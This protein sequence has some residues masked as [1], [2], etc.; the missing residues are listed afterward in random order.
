MQG[1]FLQQETGDQS[2][3]VLVNETDVGV[4]DELPATGLA[5]MILFASVDMAIFLELRGCTGWTHFSCNQ[6]FL[7]TSLV[8]ASGFDQPYHGIIGRALPL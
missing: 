4:H 2:A 3:L 8:L 1:D 5:A 6:S 7:L